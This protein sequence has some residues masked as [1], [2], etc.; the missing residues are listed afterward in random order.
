[1][2]TACSGDGMQRTSSENSGLCRMFWQL[3]RYENLR[4]CDASACTSSRTTAGAP[5][6][7]LTTFQSPACTVAAL[8]A[9]FRRQRHGAHV[10]RAV[11]RAAPRCAC[12]A[13]CVRMCVNAKHLVAGHLVQLALDDDELSD[14]L[15]RVRA[16]RYPLLLVHACAHLAGVVSVTTH[17]IVAPKQNL[18]TPPLL[19]EMLTCTRTPTLCHHCAAAMGHARPAAC[20]PCEGIP[21]VRERTHP[22]EFGT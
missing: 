9:G 16:R 11:M 22:R 8:Q 6:G 18:L 7:T 13:C 2:V 17:N 15:Q 3:R 21:C 1:M 20:M 12:H 4:S 5:S 10:M 14:P 19:R